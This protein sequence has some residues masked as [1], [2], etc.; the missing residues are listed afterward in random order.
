LSGVSALATLRVPPSAVS[1]IVATAVAITVAAGFF[2]WGRIEGVLMGCPP[3]MEGCMRGSRI[4]LLAAASLGS[5]IS[6]R[7]APQADT[8]RLASA[9]ASGACASGAA[10]LTY[11][12]LV[13]AFAES[14]FWGEY[15]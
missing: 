10:A 1:A 2:L 14:V 3:D 15:W 5:I 12:F 9:I 7:S 8:P 4:G 13:N 11:A 6:F